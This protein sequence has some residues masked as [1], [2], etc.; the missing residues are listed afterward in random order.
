MLGQRLKF[1]CFHSNTWSF[2]CDEAFVERTCRMKTIL[3]KEIVDGNWINNFRCT[4][5]DD[6]GRWGKC[7]ITLYNPGMKELKYQ[8]TRSPR[9]VR[10]IKIIIFFCNVH[11]ML[12]KKLISCKSDRLVRKS[13]QC[14]LCIVPVAIS[15]RSPCNRCKTEKYSCMH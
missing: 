2:S 3:V 5:D 4:S 14:M 8:A 15:K 6:D 12:I 1:C 13:L 11:W 10:H 9:T 7:V